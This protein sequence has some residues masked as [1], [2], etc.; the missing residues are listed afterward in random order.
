MAA[1]STKVLNTFRPVFVSSGRS[2]SARVRSQRPHC[3]AKAAFFPLETSVLLAD[4]GCLCPAKSPGELFAQFTPQS[5]E[6]DQDVARKVMG[7]VSTLDIGDPPTL[8]RVFRLYCIEGLSMAQV[9][10]ELDFSPAVI[11]LR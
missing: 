9:A 1:S 11:L 6:V 5:K 10:E 8:L 3:R 2:A 7:I 4:D